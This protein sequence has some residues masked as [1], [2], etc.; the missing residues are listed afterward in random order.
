MPW[1]AIKERPETSP[2][3]KR[4]WLTLPALV[5]CLLWA[6]FVLL[7][8]AWKPAQTQARYRE[9]ASAALGRG[10]FES[11]RVACERLLQT[12]TGN[13]NDSAFKLAIS[14]RYLGKSAEAVALLSELAP[15][16]RPGYPPAHLYL[17]RTLLTRTNL[18]V[19]QFKAAETHL[20]HAVSVEPDML[21]AH[22][23]LGQIYMQPGGWDKA[24]EHLLK[25]VP[26]RG[27]AGLMLAS[28]AAAQ[29]DEKGA[30][31]WAD[32]T[33]KHFSGLLAQAPD[34]L[35]AARIGWA[36]AQVMLKDYP[37][38]LA[39]LDAGWKL[40]RNK[41]YPPA[42]GDVCAL[43][44]RDAKQKSPGDVATRL[45]LVQQGLEFA[46][47]NFGLL[48]ELIDL[49]HL[50]GAEAGTARTMLNKLLAETGEFPL[51][52]FCLGADAWERGAVDEAR[53]HF[54]MAFAQAPHLPYVANNM[55]MVL[56]AGEKADY[57]Q[58]LATIQPVVEKFPDNAAFRDT[59]GHI[60]LKLGRYQE[61]VKDL[62]FALPSLPS[63]ALMHQAL[64]EAYRHLGLKDLADQHELLAKEDKASPPAGKA[65]PIPP[66]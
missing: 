48:Q 47:Q 12:K 14:L 53:Q 17:A 55:A 24:R 40:A 46:P 13:W 25:V 30:R 19:Q 59:R 42:M 50:A 34:D 43:W 22:A 44:V 26:K 1:V 10:D 33:V 35:P 64:A 62:E 57:A 6:G 15:M 58:A 38:A 39:T 20:L 54:G 11:A 9:I 3:W 45:K 16:N 52:H 7:L 60:L 66:K 61:A 29:G 65:K 8:V 18:S 23:L 31:Q 49:S 37:A 2:S 41:A 36:Q 27:D 4:L 28:V 51:L 56:S 63:K 21:D 32:R 5:A